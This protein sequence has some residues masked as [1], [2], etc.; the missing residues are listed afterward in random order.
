MVHNANKALS[1]GDDGSHFSLKSWGQSRAGEKR[2]LF[3]KA[4]ALG[5]GAQLG[6]QQ[7]W[8][9]YPRSGL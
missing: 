4:K 5:G 3:L 8:L 7:C 2:T 9:T 6:C 1:G